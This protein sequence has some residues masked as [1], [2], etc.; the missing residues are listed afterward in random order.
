VGLNSAGGV[1]TQIDINGDGVP[2]VKFREPCGFM[3]Q[4]RGGKAVAIETDRAVQ[5]EIQGRKL[6]LRAHTPAF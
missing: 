6:A 2:D 1:G 4:L 5:A 3:I